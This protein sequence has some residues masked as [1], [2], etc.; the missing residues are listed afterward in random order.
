M[1]ATPLGVAAAVRHEDLLHLALGAE[2]ALR[3]RERHQDGAGVAPGAAG[4]DDVGDP[5]LEHT[6]RDQ[7]DD[8]VAGARVELV[9]RLAV[10]VHGA[11]REI[12]ERH[13][14]ARR[15]R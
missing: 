8:V 4:V 14:R 11:G 5:Q 9:G 10:E 13:L 6:S 7:R 3:G 1:R 2:R 12:R 15:G